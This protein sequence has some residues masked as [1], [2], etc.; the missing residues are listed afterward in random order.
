[1]GKQHDIDFGLGRGSWL[2]RRLTKEERLPTPT[3]IPLFAI[4][5]VCSPATA[6]GD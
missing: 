4:A 1:M 2:M 3:G 6:D 5:W